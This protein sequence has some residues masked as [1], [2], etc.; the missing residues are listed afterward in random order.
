MKRISVILLAIGLLFSLSAL[1]DIYRWKDENGKTHY[2]PTLPPEYSDKPYDIL[3]DSGV[4]LKHVADPLAE[5]R[6]PAE[7]DEGDGELEPLRTD[8]EIRVRSDNLLLLRY[9]SEDDIREAMEVE[10]SQLGYDARLIN[11]S[12]ASVTTAIAAQVRNASNR[13][14]A[15][16]PADENLEKEINSLR[17]RLRRNEAELSGLEAREAKIRADFE[18]DMERYR[19]LASGGKPGG[20][21]EEG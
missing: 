20:D 5:Q 10:V 4:L 3:S 7:E 11:Q 19:Y 16:M 17:N 21:I 9:H 6:G 18:R 1:A 14:R 13:Q 15:G 2:S 12:L 8:Q